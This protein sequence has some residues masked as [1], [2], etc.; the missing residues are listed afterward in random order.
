M[1]ATESLKPFG[2]GMQAFPYC[3]ISLFLPV[4]AVRR[5]YRH[6]YKSALRYCPTGMSHRKVHRDRWCRRSGVQSPRSC[7]TTE[8]AQLDAGSTRSQ[9]RAAP[10]DDRGL[11]V[12]HPVPY[13]CSPACLGNHPGSPSGRASWGTPGPVASRR[14]AVNRGHGP[15][16]GRPPNGDECGTPPS[17]RG[18]CQPT[19]PGGRRPHR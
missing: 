9:I 8:G 10:K 3:G 11:G 7:N 4:V 2:C 12:R 17:Y 5:G 13:P 18:R 15:Q 19:Q 16:G 1:W 14:V 6:P